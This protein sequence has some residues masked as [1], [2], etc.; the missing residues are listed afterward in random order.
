[1]NDLKWNVHNDD[2][3]RKMSKGSVIIIIII[4]LLKHGK[5]GKRILLHYTYTTLIFI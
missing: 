4:K 1:M 5:R 3:L 2:I